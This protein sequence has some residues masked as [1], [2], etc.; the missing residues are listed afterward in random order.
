[1]ADSENKKLCDLKV[2][3]LRSE[4]EKRGLE[5]KGVKQVLHDRL[6]KVAIMIFIKFG[7]FVICS[8]YVV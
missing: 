6:A 5:S 4:L 3:E 1:M 2:V 7:C 8:T